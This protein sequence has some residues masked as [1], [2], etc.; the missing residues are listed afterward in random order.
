MI[1]GVVEILTRYFASGWVAG[2][3]AAS[4][5]VVAEF[6]GQCLG[7][8][9]ADIERPDLARNPRCLRA[10]IVCFSV[11]L[12][13]SDL[14]HVS[15]R[16]IESTNHLSIG[17]N[18]RRDDRAACQI[19]VLGSPRS[20]TSELSATLAGQLDL[21]WLGEGHVAPAFA[22]AARALEGDGRDASG[23]RKFSS[24][25]GQ[26]SIIHD[27]TR[28][29]YYALHGSA[30]FLDKTPGI[31]MIKSAIF[32]RECFEDAKFIFIRRNG[33]SNVLSRQTK[34]GGPFEANCRDWAAAMDGWL[35]V[36]ARLPHYL[37]IEQETMLAQ[38][39]EV[40]AAV[41]AY[42]DLPA[43]RAG[44]AASLRDGAL[45]RTGA[46]IGKASLNATGWTPAQI[47]AFRSL[48]GPT[49]ERWG[50]ALD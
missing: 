27:L 8:A 19:F 11:P 16:P 50:Y 17:A 2:D 33:I 14:D 5:Y 43:P 24:L 3:S 42:L 1:S 7:V 49:M 25:A 32:L 26:K 4:G 38:P 22:S 10:F 41:T 46:G 15:I 21:P 6:Q 29:A 12:D 31:P 37:E 34:F 13:A 23:V 9:R 36:R 47:A 39:D 44:I 18:L 30:S 28:R 48:C 40:A 35:E 20:G 45:E